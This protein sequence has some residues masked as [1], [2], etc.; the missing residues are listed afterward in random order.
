MDN[1]KTVTPINNNSNSNVASVDDSIGETGGG[2]SVNSNAN[3]SLLGGPSISAE[4]NSASNTSHCSYRGGNS[5]GRGMPLLRGGVR[6][7]QYAGYNNNVHSMHVSNSM[8]EHTQIRRT[9]SSRGRGGY[10]GFSSAPRTS[11]HQSHISNSPMQQNCGM[12]RCAPGMMAGSK[13]GRYDGTV[14]NTQRPTAPK[15]QVPHHIPTVQ[16][17][18]TYGTVHPQAQQ[19]QK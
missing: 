8:T 2:S 19:I 11:L 14:Y 16:Q 10:S 6:S 1:N 13:R 18:E 4:S 3:P 9:A 15:Y 5:R 7:N 12:K 17:Q